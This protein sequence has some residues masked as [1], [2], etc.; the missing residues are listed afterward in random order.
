MAQRANP[1]PKR[2]ASESKTELPNPPAKL[3]DRIWRF[4]IGSCESERDDHA[5]LAMAWGRSRSAGRFR[6]DS[7]GAG[8]DLALNERALR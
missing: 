4:R 2:E 7:E 3:P 1:M 5:T 6:A 8:A